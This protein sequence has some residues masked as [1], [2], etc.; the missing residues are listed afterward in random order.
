MPN[1]VENTLTIRKE[2]RGFVINENGEVDFNLIRPMPETMVD[3]ISPVDR[4]AIYC[5]LSEK[6]SKIAN[7]FSCLEHGIDSDIIKEYKE[8]LNRDKFYSRFREDWKDPFPELTKE[9][10]IDEK[11]ELGK[12]YVFN[13][14][15]YGVY[16]WYEWSY[17][18]WGVKW[19][20][21]DTDIVENGDYIKVVFST[22]WR[23]PCNWLNALKEK[24]DFHLAW[25]EEQGYRG[26]VYTQREEDERYIFREEL[27][28]LEYAETED[29][30]WDPVDD[31]E[32][33]D[34]WQEYCLSAVFKETA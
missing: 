34:C 29:G 23:Y 26:V 16:D 28:M 21:S 27:D 1:W 8:D 19:N 22:P 18:N 7:V 13:K 5:Y 31:G 2:D 32:Y 15:N 10:Y 9:Q 11:Y 12:R 4:E 14:E 33:G 20:A 3:T 17:K 25:E 30:F 24:C 6:E